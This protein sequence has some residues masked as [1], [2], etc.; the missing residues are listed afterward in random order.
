MLE[1]Y[2]ARQNELRG[3]YRARLGPQADVEDLVQD[4]YVK[5]RN[6][7]GQDVRNPAAFLYR[8]AHNHMLDWLRRGRRNRARDDAWRRTSTTVIG[9]VEMVEDPD[10]ETTLI[11]RQRLERLSEALLALPSRT[12]GIFR[13]HKFEGLTYAQTA[14]RLGLSLK[15]VEKHMSAALAHLYAKVGR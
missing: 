6:L 1:T 4:L 11:A 8:L 10:A 14:Q 9:R 2:L 3:F 7:E 13:L 5:I 15:T 12:Q